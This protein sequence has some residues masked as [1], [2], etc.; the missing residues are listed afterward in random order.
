MPALTAK[1]SARYGVRLFGYVLA[2]TLLGSLFVGGGIG[3]MY[4]LD[5]AVLENLPLGGTPLRNFTVAAAGLG[6]V[7]LGVLVFVSGLAV[8][9]FTIVADAVR[10]GVERSSLANEVESV[11]SGSTTASTPSDDEPEREAGPGEKDLPP[12]PETEPVDADPETAVDREATVADRPQEPGSA[13]PF[14]AAPEADTDEPAGDPFAETSSPEP[15]GAGTSDPFDDGSESEASADPF[16]SGST[17]T[18]DADEQGTAGQPDP[19]A[20]AAESASEERS[21]EGVDP[22]DPIDDP[23][24]ASTDP[25][26][27]EDTAVEEWESKSP[28]TDAER[29]PAGPSE[30]DETWREEIEAKLDEREQSADDD[31][32]DDSQQS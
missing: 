30:S 24:S 7:A 5:P 22:S 17:E 25:F 3:L 6:V 29:P 12:E 26:A 31:E 23:H 21:R 13:D 16:E 19:F 11:E 20:T 14:A 10:V 18:P 8:V 28:D 1:E 27:E 15:S 32:D 2:T 4:A 9:A